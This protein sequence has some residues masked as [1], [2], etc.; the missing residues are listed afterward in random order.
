[1]SKNLQKFRI[2]E[3]PLIKVMGYLVVKINVSGIVLDHLGTLKE[4]DSQSP[5]KYDLSLFFVFPLLI[6]ILFSVLN[7]R[8]DKDLV[9]ILINVFAI[10]AGLLFNL[11]ILMYDVI[12]KQS[13]SNG[14]EEKDKIKFRLLKEIYYN[15]SFGIFLSLVI[16]VILP[17]SMIFLSQPFNI[18]LSFVVFS[19]SIL[20]VLTLL[21]I[22]KRIHNLLSY[23]IEQMYKQCDRR[24]VGW[25]D[26]KKHN[27][28]KVKRITPENRIKIRSAIAFLG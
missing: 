10:F 16:V 14:K 6:S 13:R 26:K 2:N 25:I 21:M 8:L 1:M 11:L 4:L 22:L 27:I 7:I 23:D 28:F 20:F 18:F 3:I 19:L 24:F 5:S 17:I 9:S 15:I 12:S